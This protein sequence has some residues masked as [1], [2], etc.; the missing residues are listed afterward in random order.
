MKWNTPIPTLLNAPGRHILNA[1]IIPLLLRCPGVDFRLWKLGQ[2]W[3]HGFATSHGRGLCVQRQQLGFKDTW[4][5]VLQLLS[6]FLNVCFTS[7][8]TSGTYNL[9]AAAVTSP[10]AG[11]VLGLSL[12]WQPPVTSWGLVTSSQGWGWG[13]LTLVGFGGN[14]SYPDGMECLGAFHRRFVGWAS[15]HP[16][17][18]S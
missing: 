17:L 8:H 4:V 7:E 2:C 10:S 11:P 1:L 12:P 3:V 16:D 6:L 15:H 18:E 5:I 9:F 14:H 13:V